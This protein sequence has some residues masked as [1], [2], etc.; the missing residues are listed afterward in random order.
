MKRRKNITANDMFQFDDDLDSDEELGNFLSTLGGVL[1]GVAKGALNAVTGGVGGQ[2]LDAAGGAVKGAMSKGGGGGGGG[3]TATPAGIMRQA[4]AAPAKSA[5]QAAARAAPS[6][7]QHAVQAATPGMKAAVQ[8]G[9]SGVARAAVNALPADIKSA[10]KQAMAEVRAGELEQH[11]VTAR[12]ASAVDASLHPPLAAALA[13]VNQARLQTDVT[14]EHNAIN[15]RNTFET[16][17][18]AKLNDLTQKVG[19]L[20]GDPYYS[21]RTR[22][23]Y[24]PSGGPR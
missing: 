9:G 11:Q 8:A 18:Q 1:G 12:L 15:R 4:I 2:L 3:A 19:E 13:A 6:G 7:L 21:P 20:T 24:D 14:Q 23:I 16:T 10:V 17:V 5:V 22:A